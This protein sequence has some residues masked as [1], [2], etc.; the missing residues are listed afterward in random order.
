MGVARGQQSRVL[1]AKGGSKMRRRTFFIALGVGAAAI[2]QE[3]LFR[4]D[5]VIE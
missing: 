4:A 2:P 3:L 1:R 5:R